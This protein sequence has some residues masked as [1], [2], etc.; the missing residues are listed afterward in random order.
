ERERERS[1]PRRM[2][3]PSSP[4]STPSHMRRREERRKSSPLRDGRRI[5][6]SYEKRRD[7]SQIRRIPPSLS[8]D[9]RRNPSPM[10]KER[11]EKRSPERRREGG[12]GGE[13]GGEG[14]RGSHRP[15]SP[16]RS[17]MRRDRSPL[18]SLPYLIH[19]RDAIPIPLI[20]SP[21]RVRM[22]ERRERSRSPLVSPRKDLPS[23]LDVKILPLLP[24]RMEG[25]V[26]RYEREEREEKME[27]REEKEKGK[28]RIEKMEIDGREEKKKDERKEEE[29][30]EERK[31]H[32]PIVWNDTETHAKTIHRSIG[33][34]EGMEMME[35]KRKDEERKE[36][37]KKEKEKEKE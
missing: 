20:S 37:E 7:R 23:L 34:M 15:S 13:G 33:H 8:M 31:R 35:R 25:R 18:P 29:K 26:K 32:I 9:R 17:K 11:R 6:P 4:P 24:P 28:E 19:K 2:P 5:S 30:T 14:R 1:P 36:E 22:G 12:G 16:F 10:K 21:N 3:S 27:R